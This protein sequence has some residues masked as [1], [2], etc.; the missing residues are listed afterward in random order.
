[1]AGYNNNKGNIQTSSGIHNSLTVHEVANYEK[2]VTALPVFALP[3]DL[4]AKLEK[5]LIFQ[6]HENDIY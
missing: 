3:D 1:M 6:A 2:S 4:V 5:V